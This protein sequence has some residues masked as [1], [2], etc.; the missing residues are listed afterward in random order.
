LVPRTG[1]EKLAALLPSGELVVWP[2]AGHSPQLERPDDFMALLAASA[3][4][5]RQRPPEVAHPGTRMVRCRNLGL[6]AAAVAPA[7]IYRLCTTGELPHFRV[8]AAIRI[9]EQD[10]AAFGR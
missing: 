6:I 5:G 9:R 3:A 7:T 1:L 2:D 10:L 8:G 4:T